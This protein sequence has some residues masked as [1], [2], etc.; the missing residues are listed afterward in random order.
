MFDS[1]SSFYPFIPPPPPFSY[2]SLLLFCFSYFPFFFTCLFSFITFFSSFF[3]SCSFLLLLF[4]LLHFLLLFFPFPTGSP[5][6][7]K[8]LISDVL[9]PIS[10]H[11]LS[12]CWSPFPLLKFLPFLY[13][14]SLWLLIPVFT[15]HPQLLLV[16]YLDLSNTLFEKI[17]GAYRIVNDQCDDDHQIN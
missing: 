14:R 10:S 8:S 5:V 2:F 1:A 17:I 4:P 3:F 11:F 15:S 13:F 16:I 9:K 7:S 12:P 6:Y